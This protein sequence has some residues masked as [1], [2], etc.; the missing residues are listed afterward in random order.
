[1]NYTDLSSSTTSRD[2]VSSMSTS[3]ITLHNGVFTI[4][5]YSDS[6]LLGSGS[7]G[8]VFLGTQHLPQT[9]EAVAIKVHHDKFLLQREVQIYNYL[10][11]YIKDGYVNS[12][13]IPRMLWSGSVDIGEKRKEAIVMEKLGKSFD[14]VFDA[15]DKT[16]TSGTVCWFAHHALQLLR[17]LHKLGIVHRDIKPDN[18][19]IGATPATQNTLH[20]FDF[21]L[22]SQY[23]DKEGSHHPKKTGLSLIGTMR[24]A[25]QN[26]HRGILQSRRDDLEALFYVLLYF[27]NGTLE[28][29]HVVKDVDDRL[30]RS[31]LILEHKIQLMED[32]VPKVLREYFTY[33]RRLEYSE[34]PDYEKWIEWFGKRLWTITI[35]HCFP[36]TL[37]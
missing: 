17:D 36:Y 19:A 9:S 15:S 11:K 32:D 28:W 18:F 31:K 33:V 35:H 13:H 37:K 24:Y 8:H 12:L 26:N 34:T 1:M 4:D 30:I 21:G 22:S 6:G 2:I 7:Y 27:H 14:V 16:W 20:L 5:D 25:S 29:K 23:I 10:W 3:T